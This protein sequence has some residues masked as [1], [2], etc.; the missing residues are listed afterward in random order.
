[1]TRLPYTDIV[2][3][4]VCA[5]EDIFKSILGC[6][7]ACILGSAIPTILLAVTSGGWEWSGLVEGFGFWI[8]AWVFYLVAAGMAIWGFAFVL[9]HVWCIHELMQGTGYPL[10]VIAVSFM[11][12]FT[13]S[14]IVLIVSQDDHRIS[15]TI[16]WLVFVVPLAIY[17]IRS[18]RT[19]VEKPTI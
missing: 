9:V 12:Q 17:V 19:R 11:A 13:L 16:G 14:S 1:M 3:L 5:V 10:R 7:I 6:L 8:F 15:Q 18:Y 4:L 2:Q